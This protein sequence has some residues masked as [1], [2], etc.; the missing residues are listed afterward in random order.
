MDF[1]LHSRFLGQPQTSDLAGSLRNMSPYGSVLELACKEGFRE[2]DFGRS[3]PDTG[4]YRFKEQWGAQPHQLHWHYW[5][6]SGGEL[7]QLN[8]QDPRRNLSIKA[9]QRLPLVV[10]N[11]LGPHIVK[12]LP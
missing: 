11:W 7:P 10:T 3:T 2:F 5:V 12:Y 8:P 9:W 4:T 1:G 6:E